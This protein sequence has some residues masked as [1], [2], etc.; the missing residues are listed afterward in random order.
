[1]WLWCFSGLLHLTYHAL[2]SSSSI[3]FL[4]ISFYLHP[5]FTEPFQPTP[6]F[7]SKCSSDYFSSCWATKLVLNASIFISFSWLWTVL[8]SLMVSRNW[9]SLWDVGWFWCLMVQKHIYNKG[10]W[11]W[12]LS[13]WFEIYDTNLHESQNGA[14]WNN[15]NCMIYERN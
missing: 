4:P 1:M 10:N 12:T 6:T 5:A 13:G 9:A 14:F 3:T 2:I 8:M 15:V 7:A 11:N